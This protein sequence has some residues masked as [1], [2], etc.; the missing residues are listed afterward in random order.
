MSLMKSVI[1][2]INT[3]ND[4][5]GFIV[6]FLFLPITF[7]A[8]FEVFMRYVVGKPTIW[9]WDMN[10]Q[11]FAPLVMLSGGYTLLY[12]GHVAVDVLVAELSARK[13]AVLELFMSIIFFIAMFVIIWKGWQI[14][15]RS[16]MRGEAYATIWGPPLWTIK[17][18]VPI[19]AFFML[20]QGI[21]KFLSDLQTILSPSEFEEKEE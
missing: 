17:M 11:L 2:S 7:I 8:V 13:R 21:S 14:G 1:S 16:M 12:G 3:V 6:S 15:W 20:L 4:K 5:L 9:A 18:W 19:G 10:M